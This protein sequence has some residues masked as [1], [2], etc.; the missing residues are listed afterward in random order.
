MTK[1]FL[2]QLFGLLIILLLACGSE[3]QD[4]PVAPDD[5]EI[6]RRISSPLPDDTLY[7]QQPFVLKASVDCH[8]PIIGLRVDI[9]NR[10]DGGPYGDGELAYQF[11]FD[12]PGQNF[13]DIDTT[14]VIPK[15]WATAENNQYRFF[16]VEIYES[17][18]YR[19]G[20]SSLFILP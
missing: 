9:T 17:R 4:T 6:F 8:N 13:F 11:Y 5:S 2:H 10:S 19:D 12:A 3:N 14:I 18:E 16:V 7:V 1:R 20:F 15:L